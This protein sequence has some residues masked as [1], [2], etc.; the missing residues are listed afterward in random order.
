LVNRADKLKASVKTIEDLEAPT[1]INIKLILII[2]GSIIAA[3]G[4][5][6]GT[7]F[8]IKKVKKTRKENATDN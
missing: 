3:G 1:E 5:G 4:L 2:F 8:V 6:V 7:W